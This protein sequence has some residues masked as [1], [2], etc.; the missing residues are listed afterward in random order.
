MIL[1]YRGQKTGVK[2]QCPYGHKSKNGWSSGV[3]NDGNAIVADAQPINGEQ[4]R[5]KHLLAS[6]RK[7]KILYV[8]S[9]SGEASSR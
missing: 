2:L 9:T 1:F 7:T 8:E 5:Y 4:I 6:E 3:P